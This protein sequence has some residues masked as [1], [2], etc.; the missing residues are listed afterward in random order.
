MQKIIM[1]GIVLALTV[2]TAGQGGSAT[3]VWDAN[4]DAVD[5]YRVYY[6]MNATSTS[7][8]VDVG[9]STSCNLDN[10]SLAE[11]IQYYLCVTAYNSVGESPKSET[12]SYTP[13][14]TTPPMPPQELEVY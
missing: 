4:T 8:Q 14:D 11:N 6:G 5:G 7:N 12:V 9:N 13:P 10:L 3:L 2:L 1:L